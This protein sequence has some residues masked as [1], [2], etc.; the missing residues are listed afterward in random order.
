MQ[1]GKLVNGEFKAFT[2]DYI[3]HNGRVYVNPTETTLRQLGYKPLTT[4][5]YPED[6][7]GYYITAVY[8]E[9]DTEIVQSYEYVEIPTVENEF[10]DGGIE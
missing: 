6:R 3:R 7:E 9:T 2:G 5:E 4:A 1:F 10:N 8:T